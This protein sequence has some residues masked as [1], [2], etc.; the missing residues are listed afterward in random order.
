MI[1]MHPC[2]FTVTLYHAR[3]PQK[4]KKLVPINAYTCI[5]W[6]KQKTSFC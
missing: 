3:P 2:C 4:K 1:H 5:G 6:Q